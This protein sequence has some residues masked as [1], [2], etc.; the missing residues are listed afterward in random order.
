MSLSATATNEPTNERKRRF[1][2]ETR[3][4]LVTQ[5]LFHI[6]ESCE[7]YPALGKVVEE[8]VWSSWNL[9]DDEQ[10]GDAVCRGPSL[11]KA[12]PEE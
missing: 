12:R 4:G 2:C 3:R 6:L 7:D 9:H 10:V 5:L 11:F 8:F 1:F